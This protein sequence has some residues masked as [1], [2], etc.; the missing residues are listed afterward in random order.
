MLGVK[1][2]CS[3]KLRE[4]HYI[5]AMGE[6]Q[7]RLAALCRFEVIELPEY[8]IGDTPTQKMI[9]A[10]LEKEAQAIEK[11]IPQGAY[12]IAMCIEGTQLGSEALAMRFTE[13]ANH[14][15]S[16]VCFLIGSSFG[17]AQRLKSAA[18]E[19]LSMSKMTFPHH[20][21][22]VMLTEQVYRAFMINEG[23]RYH[24]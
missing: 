12:V 5:E 14:G 9:E 13:L 7:K 20:L 24:K 11:Q 4:R 3:G 16:R 2:I 15:K 22:R 10:A 6:Y 21:A 18:D 17:L 23:T 19:R 8:R 1:L